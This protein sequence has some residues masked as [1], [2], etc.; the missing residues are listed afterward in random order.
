MAVAV[1]PWRWPHVIAFALCALFVAGNGWYLPRRARPTLSGQALTLAG[2][3]GG[4]A[5]LAWLVP[6][7]R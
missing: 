4:L 7:L 3:F 2:F 1:A 5:L 6:L